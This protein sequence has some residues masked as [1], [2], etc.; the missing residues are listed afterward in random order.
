[1]ADPATEDLD[2]YVQDL[3]ASQ[4]R[5][6]AFVLASLG[7]YADTADVLQRTNLVLWK[8]AREFRPGA[9]FLP[10][11]LTIARYE[12]LSF[13]RDSKRDRHVFDSD[14]AELM[15]DVATEDAADPNDRRLALRACL[16]KLPG[17]N[18]ELLW[19]RYGDERS[20]RQIATVSSRSEDA[21]KSLFLRIRKALERCVEAR[22]KGSDA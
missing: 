10:W 22:L 13:V 9:P 20:I 15:L 2:A 19:M 3:T 5:L 17:H 18:R 12:I 21:V 16:E 8:K 11:A 1:M 14:V 4:S 6:R 7:N